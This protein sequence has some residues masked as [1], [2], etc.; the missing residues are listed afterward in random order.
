MSSCV[1]AC[2]RA[3]YVKKGVRTDIRPPLSCNFVS[4]SLLRHGV[5]LHFD[6]ML[7]TFCP[8]QIAKH[9]FN[10]KHE[11]ELA[12]IKCSHTLNAYLNI[13]FFFSFI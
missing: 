3:Y 7:H 5:S 10:V 6:Y 4:F 2:V 8:I 9:I 1:F 12:R 11:L 13:I